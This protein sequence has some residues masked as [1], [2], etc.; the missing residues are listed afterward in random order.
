[1]VSAVSLLSED[2]LGGLVPLPAR[3][4]VGFEVAEGF[5]SWIEQLDDHA[6]LAV[7]VAAASDLPRAILEDALSLVDLTP[8]ALRPAQSL[9][10][11]SIEADRVRFV[12]PLCRT[13]ASQGASHDAQRAACHAVTD[14]L[15]GFG[16][17]EQAAILSATSVTA[18]DED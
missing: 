10:L 18:R 17:V 6:R 16:M 5:G 3:I 2:E 12:P 7:T 11:V 13:A 8:D 1:M 14:A 15:L 9:G 4:P